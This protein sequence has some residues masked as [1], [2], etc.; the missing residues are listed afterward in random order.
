MSRVLVILAPG[1]EEIEATTI[2]DVLRRA[3]ISVTVSGL[4]ERRV[5]G[6]HDI[7]VEADSV[8]DEVNVDEYEALVLPGGLP[9]AHHL[10]DDA[11]V[12]GLVRRFH[13]R[14]RWVA[15]ICAA[16]IV[17]EK[18]GILNGRR[19]TSYPGQELP[20]SHYEQQAVVRDGRVITSRG[21]GTALS[22]ACELVACLKS[23]ELAATLAERMLVPG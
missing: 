16:P 21:V 13:D 6:S 7:R 2:I 19:A 15:A 17:L 11:R 8:L 22:F 3:E 9:G 23:P 10:R 12:T 18:A 1:F 5:T 20:S 14:G 4:D